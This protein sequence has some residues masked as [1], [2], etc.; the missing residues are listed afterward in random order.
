MTRLPPL[1][2]PASYARVCS[3]AEGA[4]RD[5]IALQAEA[6]LV[7]GELFIARGSLPGQ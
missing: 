6:R 2:A 5:L 4:G 7:R 1:R 3:S